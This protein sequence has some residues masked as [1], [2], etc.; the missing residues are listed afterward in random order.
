[1]EFVARSYNTTD[2][3]SNFKRLSVKE[4]NAAILMP[5]HVL[6]ARRNQNQFLTAE[7]I[8]NGT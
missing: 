4:E 5:L 8:Y 7:P 2:S 3:D 6:W 1:V